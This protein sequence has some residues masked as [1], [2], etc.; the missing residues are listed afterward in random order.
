MRAFTLMEL[1]IGMIISSIVISFGY[2]AYSL[3]YKQFLSYKKVKKEIVDVMQLNSILHTDLAKAELISFN[4]NKLTIDR[5]DDLPLL[6]DFNDSII[7]RKDIDVIDTFKIAAST[8]T[9]AFS[10]PEQKAVVNSFSFDAGVLGETE[11]FSFEK[12][13]SAETLMNYENKFK[14]Q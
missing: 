7:L 4:E 9:I 13:Y 6:Y 12:K 1:L 3:I 2:G 8:V 14:N 5:K 10:F 11:H